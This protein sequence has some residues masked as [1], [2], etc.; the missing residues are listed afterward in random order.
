MV[1]STW[2]APRWLGYLSDSQ[3]FGFFLQ[4][5][6][7]QKNVENVKNLVLATP[8][9]AVPL[10]TFVN[11]KWSGLG[12]HKNH[13]NCKF[14]Q[15]FQ[16]NDL[17]RA[18]QNIFFWG[19]YYNI[20]K[21]KKSSEKWARRTTKIDDSCRDSRCCIVNPCNCRHFCARNDDSCRESN[22]LHRSSLQLSS[23]LR[24][25]WRQL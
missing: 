2:R 20:K 10:I 19:C 4:K 7:T 22:Q 15:K 14:C 18:A 5:L 24:Q 21:I 9:N 13:Q 12:I 17:P 16:K 25:K 3:T 8:P 1:F 23:F 11:S 6:K